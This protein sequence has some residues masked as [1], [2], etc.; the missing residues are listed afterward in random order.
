MRPVVAFLTFVGESAMILGDA[1]HRAPRRPVEWREALVQMAF[2]GVASVPIVALTAFFSG[3]VL[4]LYLTVFLRQYGAQ[5]FVGATVGLTATREIGPVIAGIMVSARAG[6]AMAAQIGTMAVTEQ[7]DA[8]RMLGVHPTNYLVIPRLLAGILM[9]PILAL[10]AIWMA[11]IGGMLVAAS[12]GLSPAMFLQSVQQYVHAADIVKGIL[13]GPFFGLIV[14]LV[15]CQQGLRT[16]N[17]AVGVGRAT[18]HAVVI[19]MVLVYVA[20]FLLA[21]VM[22][23]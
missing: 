23:H 3:A 19:S 10:V 12:E 18:T 4:S 20:N 8:L 1:I 14:A 16:K 11:V 9:V 2:V 13:K 22:Y 5:A 6:S 21:R 17:G 15:A 7:I